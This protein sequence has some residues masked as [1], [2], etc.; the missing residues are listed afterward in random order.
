[1]VTGAEE[2]C[3]VQWPELEEP[4][5]LNVHT[6]KKKIK[7]KR[8]G[9]E[10]YRLSPNPKIKYIEFHSSRGDHPW[11]TYIPRRRLNRKGEGGEPYRLSPKRRLLKNVIIYFIFEFG[12]G[13]YVYPLLPLTLNLLLGVYVHNGRFIHFESFSQTHLSSAPATSRRSTSNTT[14]VCVN[15]SDVAQEHS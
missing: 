12:D 6:E 4:T 7:R 9:G 5:V 14:A 8:K 1:M 15:V 2:D 13:R 10:P 3:L 11:S